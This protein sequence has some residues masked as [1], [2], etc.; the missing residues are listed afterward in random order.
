ME[1]YWGKRTFDKNTIKQV[2]AFVQLFGFL[3][4]SPLEQFRILAILP[5]SLGSL[6]LSVTNSSVILFLGVS[7]IVFLLKVLF[8]LGT[9]RLEGFSVGLLPTSR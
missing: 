6:D 2:C 7:A 3:S 8:P 4:E 1:G 5:M 9:E